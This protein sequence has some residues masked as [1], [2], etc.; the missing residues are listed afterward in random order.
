MRLVDTCIL[1]LTLIQSIMNL[2]QQ[3]LPYRGEG[4]PCRFEL[5]VSDHQIPCAY[6]IADRYPAAQSTSLAELDRLLRLNHDMKTKEV[7]ILFKLNK[8][9]LLQKSYRE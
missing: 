8:S 2:M 9:T 5:C 6:A 4:D 7:E 3:R 1:H